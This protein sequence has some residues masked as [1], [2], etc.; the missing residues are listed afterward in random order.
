MPRA[1]V[2]VV[3]VQPEPYHPCRCPDTAGCAKPFCE[4]RRCGRCHICRTVGQ[5]AIP[6][7]TPGQARVLGRVRAMR[8]RDTR[9]TA[10]ETRLWLE[11]G[12]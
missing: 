10:A 2:V 6:M 12:S 4:N 5:D 1:M 3:T 9:M 8:D 7:L 11:Y